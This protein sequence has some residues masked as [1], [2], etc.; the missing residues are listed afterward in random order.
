[1]TEKAGLNKGTTKILESDFHFEIFKEEEDQEE[2]RKSNAFEAFMLIQKLMIGPLCLCFPYFYSRA[3][4]IGGAFGIFVGFFL[5]LYG[6]WTLQNIV[7]EIETNNFNA[8][9]KTLDDAVYYSVR[10]PNPGDQESF[11][12]KLH[13]MRNGFKIFMKIVLIIVLL[14]IVIGDLLYVANTFH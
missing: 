14:S 4:L 6:T 12:Y 1:M 9:V 3:G 2:N 8:V 13:R 5:A 10:S 7:V 11:L